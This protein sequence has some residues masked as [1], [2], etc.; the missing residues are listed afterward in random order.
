MALL[1][2]PTGWSLGVHVS[3]FH[4]FHAFFWSVSWSI[5][6]SGSVDSLGSA[7]EKQCSALRQEVKSEPIL[8]MYTI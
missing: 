6:Q 2:V 5:V 1:N 3:S 4:V 8:V 7:K